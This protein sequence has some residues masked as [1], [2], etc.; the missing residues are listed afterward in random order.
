MNSGWAETLRGPHQAQQNGGP[1]AEQSTPSSPLM[2]TQVAHQA[3][4]PVWRSEEQLCLYK[5]SAL[6]KL[7]F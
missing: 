6:V 2:L 3:P 5:Y 1:G 7:A 4:Q